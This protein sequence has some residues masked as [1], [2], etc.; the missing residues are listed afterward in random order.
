M[1]FKLQMPLNNPE[2]S[3]QNSEHSE[4]FKSRIIHLYGEETARHLNYRCQ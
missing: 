2:E 3:I 4:S 1:A